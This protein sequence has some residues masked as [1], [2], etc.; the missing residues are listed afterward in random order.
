MWGSSPRRLRWSS[1]GGPAPLN[2]FVA[3][4]PGG[5]IEETAEHCTKESHG[6]YKIKP[7][8]LPTDATQREQLVR[9]LGAK[10]SSIDMIGLDV[11]LTSEFANAGWIEPWH[12][13]SCK[14]R[15]PRTSS[16]A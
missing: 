11:I 4:Q 13:R 14:S 10:D 8:L 6:R 2:C 12:R 3:I 16:P 7:E 15:R 5:T 9:R 1:S